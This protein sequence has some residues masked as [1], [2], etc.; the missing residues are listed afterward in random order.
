MKRFHRS[1]ILPALLVLTRAPLVAADYPAKFRGALEGAVHSD[2]SLAEKAFK[3][4]SSK[5]GKNRLI[6]LYELAGLTRLT[7]DTKRSV[8]FFKDADDVAHEYEGRAV[9]SAGA[10]ARQVGAVLSNDKALKY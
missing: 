10:G 2:L 1:L 5:P 3:K 4:D 6:A 9:A 8:L 7:G